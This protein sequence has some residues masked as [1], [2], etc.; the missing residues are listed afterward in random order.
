MI[1]RGAANRL[2]LYRKVWR[3]LLYRPGVKVFVILASYFYLTVGI[4]GCAQLTGELDLSSVL[5]SHSGN[6]SE[7]RGIADAPVFKNPSSYRVELLFNDRIDYWNPKTH[8]RLMGLVNELDYSRVHAVVKV[9]NCWFENFPPLVRTIDSAETASP[10]SLV[11]KTFIEALD[12]ML[13]TQSFSQYD[14]DILFDKNKTSIV[15]SRCKLTVR[16][17][18]NIAQERSSLRDLIETAAKFPDLNAT[19]HGPP[20]RQIVVQTVSCVLLSL[21]YSIVII[22]GSWVKSNFW[23]GLW[24]TY[25]VMSCTIGALGWSVWFQT[26]V[27]PLLIWVFTALSEIMIYD[28]FTTPYVYFWARKPRTDDAM[29]AAM[30]CIMAFVIQITIVFNFCFY[31]GASCDAPPYIWYHRLKSLSL[32]SLSLALHN[33]V[34]L[35]VLAT[36]ARSFLKVTETMS[37]AV[38]GLFRGRETST[39]CPRVPLDRAIEPPAV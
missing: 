10:K 17:L 5:W 33:M 18:E 8:E 11:R 4:F 1:R 25:S 9:S 34:L 27:E 22:V 36:S 29:N 15:A 30:R 6:I 31:M 23:Y 35:S 28:Y 39:R 24:H 21:L 32:S 2:E 3:D 26:D 20:E 16:D 7:G 37:S 19:I 13:R 38:L 14:R 12:R